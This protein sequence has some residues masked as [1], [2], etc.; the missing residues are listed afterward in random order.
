M[1]RLTAIMAA[2]LLAGCATGGDGGGGEGE[3]E[4]GGGSRVEV[5]ENSDPCAQTVC[6]EGRQCN[7]ETGECEPMGA[8]HEDEDEGEQVVSGTLRIMCPTLNDEEI[9]ALLDL[10]TEAHGKG[11]SLAE[12]YSGVGGACME[13]VD[14]V[15]CALCSGAAVREVWDVDDPLPTMCP[16]MN[17]EEIAELLDL[18]TDAHEDGHSLA[19]AWII[20]GAACNDMLD[21]VGCALCAG[22]AVLEVWAN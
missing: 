5:N 21:A 2:L 9:A 3:G 11:D 18:V 4:P 13:K 10:L 1:K 14:A 8:V 6:F 17:D 16:R 7:P 15:G 22:V 20:A 19:E 12:A